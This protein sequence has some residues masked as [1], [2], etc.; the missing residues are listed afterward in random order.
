MSV[1]RKTNILLIWTA[2][3]LHFLS[4]KGKWRWIINS[5]FGLFQVKRNLKLKIT[6][7]PILQETRKSLHSSDNKIQLKK[8]LFSC[9]IFLIRWRWSTRRLFSVSRLRAASCSWTC[10]WATF[11]SWSTSAI[12]SFSWSAITSW[13]AA[14]STTTSRSL[15]TTTA[16]STPWTWS[17]G[18][19]RVLQRKQN[20]YTVNSIDLT[21]LK[22]IFGKKNVTFT[23][24][25]KFR[26][27][28]VDVKKSKCRENSSFCTQ[29]WNWHAAKN[30]STTKLWTL[31][32]K[33]KKKRSW[34]LVEKC[35]DNV[36]LSTVKTSFSHSSS[37]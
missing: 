34:C 6:I 35:N 14:T 9:C 23:P 13:S 33:Y 37:V 26:G 15:S 21:P 36:G 18:S 12:W 29:P 17:R 4:K 11:T 27:C 2:A 22:E 31:N 8:S 25:L 7:K 10:S 19:W 16:T 28:A 20:Y 5:T 1:S 30:S 3:I 32:I 24:L